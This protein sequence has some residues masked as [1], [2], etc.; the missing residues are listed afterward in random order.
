MMQWIS[1]RSL[2]L[3]ITERRSRS[4][5]IEPLAVTRT[6]VVR[7]HRNTRIKR[8]DFTALK[9]LL[10]E[11]LSPLL[12]GVLLTHNHD[13]IHNKTNGEGGCK[14][15]LDDDEGET[16][17]GFGVGG[18]TELVDEDDEADDRENADA[19]DDDVEDVTSFRVVGAV[20]K[21]EEEQGGFTCELTN[22]L[23][24]AVAVAESDEGTLGESVDDEREKD[25]PKVGLI[26]FVEET[27]FAEVGLVEE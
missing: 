8:R 13:C 6:A 2:L 18:D 15:G 7:N 25:P 21:E 1:S 5:L 3:G 16:G 17:D 19:R 20:P 23:D 26:L 27:V 24:E 9:T 4:G 10:L 14:D 22:S 12:V 11:F